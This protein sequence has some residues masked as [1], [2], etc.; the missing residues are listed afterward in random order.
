MLHYWKWPKCKRQTEVGPYVWL[1]PAPSSGLPQG[2]APLLARDYREQMSD[3][4]RWQGYDKISFWLV[5]D[6]VCPGSCPHPWVPSGVATPRRKSGH[7]RYSLPGERYRSN[8]QLA[9]SSMYF[10]WSPCHSGH[11][12]VQ[13]LGARPCCGQPL[14]WIIHS[15]RSLRLFVS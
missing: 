7:R 8:I 12:W 2:W 6:T 13:R 10:Q 9:R 15:L 5:R 11:F 4:L 1:P 3:Q 14:L